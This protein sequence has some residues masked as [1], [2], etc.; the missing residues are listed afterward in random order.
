RALFERRVDHVRRPADVDR[1]QPLGVL[2]PAEPDER[3]RVV[4]A[5]GAAHRLADG[6]RVRHVAERVFDAAGGLAEEVERGRGAAQDADGLALGQQLP[7]EHGPEE[8]GG[9]GDE[10]HA[11]LMSR[12]FLP[13][14]AP[15]AT[16]TAAT[17]AGPG[18]R[19]SFSIFIASSTTRPSPASTWWPGSTRTERT[20]PGI[21]A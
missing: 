18:A 15:G 17:V 10:D 4:D 6:R 19:S 12:S 9:A 20:R 8:A 7:D 11:K 2:R 1:A 21:G 5:L 13:T 3:R 14:A 16:W